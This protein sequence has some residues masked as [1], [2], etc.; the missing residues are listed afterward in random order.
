MTRGILPPG[1]NVLVYMPHEVL[2]QLDQAAGFLGYARSKLIR[3]A[4]EA[5][6]PTGIRDRSNSA[7]RLS[8]RTTQAGIPR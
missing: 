6:L 3:D 5:Q 2:E 8:T 7:R 4:V 1:K